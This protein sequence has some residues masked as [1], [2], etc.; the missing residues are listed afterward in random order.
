MESYVYGTE[1]VLSLNADKDWAGVYSIR[2]QGYYGTSMVFD[3][4]MSECRE[5]V[6]LWHSASRSEIEEARFLELSTG[7]KVCPTGRAS[8]ED[9]SDENEWL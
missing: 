1:R 7:S 3:G 4:T 8:G 6:S 2:L 9:W 5:W